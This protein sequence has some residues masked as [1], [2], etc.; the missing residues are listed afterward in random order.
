MNHSCPAS[1]REFIFN[2]DIE[3]PEQQETPSEH[4]PA[5]L[6]STHPKST[7]RSSTYFRPADNDPSCWRTIRRGETLRSF[8][9]RDRSF[10]TSENLQP[11]Q[12]EISSTQLENGKKGSTRSNK[13]TRT[14]AEAASR[15]I[16]GPA[17]LRSRK[18]T[19]RMKPTRTHLHAEKVGSEHSEQF[20]SKECADVSPSAPSAQ[21]ER[22][23]YGQIGQRQ[24]SYKKAASG[25]STMVAL[26]NTVVPAE[27]MNWAADIFHDQNQHGRFSN[28]RQTESEPLIDPDDHVDFKSLNGLA[29]K[30]LDS[31]EHEASEITN[32]GHSSSNIPPHD[33]TT[34]VIDTGKPMDTS[35]RRAD[36]TQPQSKSVA[37]AYRVVSTTQYDKEPYQQ[38]NSGSPESGRAAEARNTV[39]ADSISDADYNPRILEIPAYSSS[40]SQTTPNRRKTTANMS[41]FFEPERSNVK[42]CLAFPR[43]RATCF[44]L[45]QER[46]AH[47]PF[48]LLV[49][50]I[51]LHQTKG[52]CALPVLLAFIKVFPTADVL[53]TADPENIE[54]FIR[55][56]GLQ[57]KRA[58]LL[59]S[60]AKSW[61][62]SPPLKGRRYRCLNYPGT[63][64]GT[65]IALSEQPIGESDTRKAW[66][67]AH[68]PGI[69]P[70]ALDSWRIFCRDALRGNPLGSRPTA[71]ITAEDMAREMSQEWT[72]V[73][74]TDKELKAYVQ[75]R[76]IRLGWLWD[77]E[78][79][80]KRRVDPDTIRAME[81]GS[82]SSHRGYSS[83]W[84]IGANGPLSTEQTLGG[85]HS[86]SDLE[87]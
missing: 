10:L 70:Y 3:P 45:I 31:Y 29:R 20:A 14:K 47:D 46:L 18:R 22:S 21:G 5:Y 42:S 67:I 33:W 63:G 82:L 59:V 43:S 36:V 35:R 40:S 80:A 49:A 86:N 57:R 81:E 84:S 52:S 73:L 38:R 58:R 83:P 53:S 75:W 9:S 74:P 13:G 15:N 26:S 69:G 66:E 30:T 51:F 4:N 32:L 34:T 60:L 41:P 62:A 17:V 1:Y 64:A 68:L 71:A 78:S 12:L 37:A 76:W 77:P 8:N 72:S 61:L 16:T 2:M 28:S 56:L 27:D 65:D 54:P 7:R 79:G 50:V 48:K 11:S 24:H 6:K 19:C 87:C 55:C 23:I 85:Y 25:L 44:G 39:S